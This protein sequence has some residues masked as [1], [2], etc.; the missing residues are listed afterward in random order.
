VCEKKKMLKLAW[1]MDDAN[2]ELLAYDMIS[3]VSYYKQDLEKALFFH[4]K[5]STGEFEIKGSALRNVGEQNYLL[6]QK[7]KESM[8]DLNSFS[9]DDLDLDVL[10]QKGLLSKWETEQKRKELYS[11]SVG[12]RGS[13]P[14]YKQGPSFGKI[15][16]LDD[17]VLIQA[18]KRLE[19]S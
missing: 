2:F 17:N 19:R 4:E 12:R 15:K 18:F 13:T 16:R 9:E 3:L 10:V 1:I 14:N 7:L 11:A 8:L 6:S 5:F